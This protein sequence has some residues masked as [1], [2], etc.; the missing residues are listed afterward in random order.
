MMR[1]RLTNTAF[2]FMTPYQT[3]QI[4]FAWVGVWR[5]TLCGFRART[6]VFVGNLTFHL[7]FSTFPLHHPIQETSKS[8]EWRN[9]L[10]HAYAPAYATAPNFSSIP[11]PTLVPT[12]ILSTTK[13][14]T[15][16][17]NV[18]KGRDTHLVSSTAGFLSNLP[19]LVI[20]LRHT[21]TRRRWFVQFLW[22]IL[23]Y[24][25]SFHFDSI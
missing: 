13:T 25:T 9:P 15:K 24:C 5:N 8:P 22:S 23:R 3:Y 10:A 17:E 1:L 21:K 16:Y 2:R 11:V 12:L 20:T 7:Y 19:P 14:K 18:S 6:V 4:G